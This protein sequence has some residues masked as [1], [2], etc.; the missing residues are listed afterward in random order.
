LLAVRLQSRIRTV[1]GAEIGIRTMFEAPTAAAMA[2]KIG[3]GEI[4]AT[5]R[6]A[7]VPLTRSVSQTVD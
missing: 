4:P 6:P 2:E 7:L 3:T 1:F 5:T